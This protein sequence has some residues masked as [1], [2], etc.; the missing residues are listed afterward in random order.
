[1]REAVRVATFRPPASSSRSSTAK[2]GPGASSNSVTRRISPELPGVL[3]PGEN[4]IHTRGGMRTAI[5]TASLVVLAL[6]AW[7]AEAAAPM[8]PQCSAA[9]TQRRAIL[10]SGAYSTGGSGYS[11]NCGPGRAVVQLRGKS[12]TIQ[13]GRCHGNILSPRWVYFGLLAQQS[14]ARE[15][16]RS[17]WSLETGPDATRSAI[18]LSKWTDSTWPRPVRP[19]SP[20]DSRAR[21]SPS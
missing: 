19:S 20:R 16:S 6:G 21:P 11:R 4:A 18:R 15:A 12:F 10:F 2:A 17:S 5:V 3:T 7:A 14:P 9:D 1:M 13:G 8:P